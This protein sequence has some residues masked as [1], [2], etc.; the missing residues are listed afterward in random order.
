[1]GRTPRGAAEERIFAAVE[2]L[3]EAG[4]AYT[5]L[6]TGR[7]AEEAGVARSTLYV[8]F[9]DK[10]DLLVR[11]TE[12]ATTELFDVAE[13][14]VAGGGGL[15]ELEATMREVVRQ[16]RSHKALFVALNEAAAYEPRVAAFWQSRIQRFAEQ[17]E[18][19]VPA[20]LDARVTSRFLAWGAERAVFEHI[21]SDASGRGDARLAKGIARATWA[22]LGG[23]G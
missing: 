19:R 16:Q 17:V 10:A 22:V 2:R 15:P 18:P 5:S 23:E 21:G 6:S 4:E 20:G 1:M 12:A 11:L 13:R 14:W 7:I 8:H 9:A 3:L